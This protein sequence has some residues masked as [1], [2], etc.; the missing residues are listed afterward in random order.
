M[1]AYCFPLA[2]VGV[3][4]LWMFLRQK[5]ISR[6]VVFEKLRKMLFPVRV[7]A[8]GSSEAFLDCYWL[9]YFEEP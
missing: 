5:K 4:E 2:S 8:M 6:G 7:Y 9:L 3:G 1:S